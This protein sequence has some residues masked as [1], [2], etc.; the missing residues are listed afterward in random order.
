MCMCVVHIIYK[1]LSAYKEQRDRR[2][3]CHRQFESVIF[4][5]K[6][7]EYQIDFGAQFEF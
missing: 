3:I 7:V 4:V 2:E 6:H 1:D 5:T